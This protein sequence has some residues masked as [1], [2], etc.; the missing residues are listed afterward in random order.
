MGRHKRSIV[1]GAW[2]AS[3]AVAGIGLG[4]HASA[5]QSGA[6]TDWA[7]YKNRSFT[8]SVDQHLIDPALVGA[9]DLHAHSDP[10]SYPRQWDA[11]DVARLAKDRGLRG[12]VL[13]NHYTETAGLAFL[14]RK[15]GPPGVEVFGGLTLD[16]P[17]GGVNP[18]AVRYMAD[19]AGHYGRIVWMPT[20][21]S[22]H[23]ITYNK[24]NRPFVRVARNG[25][26][27]PEVLE[28]LSLVAEHDLTLATGH[29]SADEALSIV[30][31]AKKRGVQRII[32]THPLLGPQYTY[33]SLDQL[34]QAASLGAYMEIVGRNLTGPPAERARVLEAI[35]VIGPDSTFVSS[36]SGLTGS[37][38][39]TDALAL[40]A[41]ALREAG[42]DDA[43]LARMFRENPA[44]LI[45]LAPQ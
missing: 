8:P 25:Q 30:R 26:L 22:E 29:V 23:E 10:D 35:R 31:E 41:K 37:P 39:H 20:H 42:F 12:I 21:D 6:L 38:N 11:F 36:D 32:L 34:R 44:R 13:K 18:Q 19:V 9:V 5:G 40:A 15:Y 27:L 7:S 14:V 45:K 43:A 24:D 4:L 16:L 28:V 17:V 33:M 3:V 1:I 2:V